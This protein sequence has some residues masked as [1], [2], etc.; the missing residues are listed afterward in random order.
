MAVYAFNND[1]VFMTSSGYRTNQTIQHY[2]ESYELY[3]LEKGTCKYFIDNR[4][5]EIN[6]G[7]L[8]VIPNGVIHK[9]LYGEDFH[10]RLLINC[11]KK[12]I[13]TFAL[14]NLSS[15]SPIYTN[16]N[17]VSSIREVF[18]K[19]GKECEKSDSF[20]EEMLYSCMVE[21]FALLSRNVNQKQLLHKT[22]P[23]VEEAVDYINTN[24]ADDVKLSTV[25]EKNFV[26]QEHLS[27]VFK[28]ETGFNFNEFVVM[29]RLRH[30]QRLLEE[31]PK[32]SIT[33][34]AYDCGFNDSNY[35]SFTF[36]K[37]F[38]KSPKQYVK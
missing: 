18:V 25:A 24:F 2:H 33:Q 6:E 13:P 16:D 38:G 3:F 23:L 4:T 9:T 37:V 26:S 27:R 7:D 17:I 5:Y 36:K 34:L 8:V 11:H 14:S 35:F 31:N 21:L 10:E 30:A 20:S 15:F 29:V 32:R 1:F 19:M 28:K 12:Y 22:S